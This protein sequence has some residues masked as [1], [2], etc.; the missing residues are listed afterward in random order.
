MDLNQPAVEG[1]TVAFTYARGAI[2]SSIPLTFAMTPRR[3]RTSHTKTTTLKITPVKP[4]RL[5]LDIHS[6]VDLGCPHSLAPGLTYELTRKLKK[7]SDSGQKASEL[8]RR[9]LE[10]E[11]GRA[12]EREELYE[13]VEYLLT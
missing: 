12:I 9:K 3:P 13:M 5:S 11:R 10:M 2:E 6:S 8:I 4:V 7:A 1:S